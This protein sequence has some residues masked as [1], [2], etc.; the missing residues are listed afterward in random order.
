MSTNKFNGGNHTCCQ[1]HG[2]VIISE[3]L[4]DF[5]PSLILVVQFINLVNQVTVAAGLWI[6]SDTC[7]LQT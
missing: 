1:I 2:L 4:F 7:H 6:V 3:Q 5:A